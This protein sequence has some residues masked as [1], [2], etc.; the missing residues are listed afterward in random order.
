M[1]DPHQLRQDY[2]AAIGITSWLPRHPLPG[3]APSGEW[4]QRFS[5]ERADTDFDDS[6]F[7]A[8]ESTGQPA[9]A[10]EQP[11][12]TPQP[13]PSVTSGGRAALAALSDDASVAEIAPRT[14][15]ATPAASAPEP[16]P[17]S[18]AAVPVTPPNLKLAFVVVGDLLVVDSLPIRAPRGFSPAHQRLL[19]G[20][21]RALGIGEAPSSPAL[22][23]WPMLASQTL[24][25]GPAEALKAVQRKLDL[26]LQARPLRRAL[27]LGDTAARWVLDR[28][29]PLES[30]RGI[31]FT[32]R[33]EVPVV[34]SCSLSQ[35]L[36]LPEL[37]AELW[38][39]LQPLVRSA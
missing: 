18:S 39:D 13:R 1:V 26:T 35:L 22:L 31:R 12:A 17:R 7:P 5:G 37:K 25:Q 33:P 20:I 8:E 28:E 30:L 19:S 16:P 11:A 10:V 15:P 27:L 9:S 6:D 36:Q 24:D 34:C 2:L 4:I 38:R 21:V 23:S 29:E 32:L 3:A 14:A